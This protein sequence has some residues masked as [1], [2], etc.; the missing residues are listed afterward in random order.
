MARAF[1]SI[2][3]LGLA[4]GISASIDSGTL[5]ASVVLK[6]CSWVKMCGPLGCLDCENGGSPG[7]KSC[8]G[9]QPSPSAPSLS[10]APSADSTEWCPSEKD[11]EI[12]GGHWN[13][14]GWTMTGGGGVHGRQTF[15]LLGGYIEFEIDTTAAKGGVN[16]N[17]Y[18]VF[19]YPSY[20]N[21]TND[22]DIQAVGKPACME[23]DI[24]E[25]NGN[26]IAQTTWHTWPNHNG[27]CDQGGCW[28]QMYRKGKTQIRAEFSSDG[29]M[30]VYMDGSKVDVTHPVPSENAHRYVHD[31]MA[32]KG[33]Q[34]QS[35][36]W[37]GWVPSG[38]CPG[39]GDLGG[40]TFSITDVRVSGTVVQGP[41]PTRCSVRAPEA[42]EKTDIAVI[43]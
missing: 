31:T 17:F 29:W 32:S 28:G 38:N 12:D 3:A 21:A 35:S 5:N 1:K 14:N 37:V 41:E 9:S 7:Y 8:C 43:I 16:N 36:Q 10:P 34:I 27:D 6:D 39:G 22:C 42:Q 13:G 2:V 18:L 33:A 40:S 30:T 24:I 25:N 15:N 23:M 26:C 4:S 20:F 19:P 11:F